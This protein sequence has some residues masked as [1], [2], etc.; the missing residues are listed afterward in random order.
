MR[1]TIVKIG[2]IMKKA[3]E[4]V[5]Q[6]FFPRRC[7]VCDGIVRPFGEK[8]C[9]ECLPKLKVV[10]S[11]W[12]MRCGKKLT[13]EREFCSD[14][15]RRGHKYDRARTLYEYGCAAPSIYRFKYGGRQEYG[16]FFGEEMG[17]YLGDFIR[18]AHPDV[19]VPVPLHRKKL[20]RRGYNQAACLAKA[21]GRSLEVPVDEKLVKRVRNTAPMKRLNPAE[22]QNNLKKAFIIGRNDVKLYDR[23]ILVDDI[24]TTGTTLDEIAA[25][26][27]EHGVSKV[28]CVTLACRS[29][30]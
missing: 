23:I 11:P 25:L 7:P 12:C 27:K 18:R 10:D 1:N 13:E 9:P 19:I 28:Y 16:E 30:V 17:R 4:T 20:Q 22:R 21:L 29:G 14:C 8:I 3:G 24:Y 2:K 6:L 5:L 26:L 15:K